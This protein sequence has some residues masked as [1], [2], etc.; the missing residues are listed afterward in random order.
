[1]KS[2]ALPTLNL[3]GLFAIHMEVS[4]RQLDIS[5]K[6]AERSVLE[7]ESQEK[8]L[9][10]CFLFRA[11]PAAHGIPGLGV[12]SELQ[13]PANATSESHLQPTPQLVAMPGP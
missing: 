12:E 7:M 2:C 11:T 6:S 13:L 1:M 5:F 10:F 4:R 9:L 8:T 3:K